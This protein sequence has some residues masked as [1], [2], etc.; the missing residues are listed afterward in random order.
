VKTLRWLG[1]GAL[2]CIW[3]LGRA[4]AGEATGQDRAEAAGKRLVG[5]PAPRMVMRT[6]DGDTIDL[7]A[8]Y[9][10]KSVYL[11][12]WATWCVPC[13]QQ[14]PHFEHTYETA[15]SD[16]AVIAVNAGFNDSLEEIRKYRRALGITMPIVLDDGRLGAAFNLRVTPQHIVIGRDGRIQYVG[17]LADARLDAAL[18]AARQTGFPEAPAS[19]PAMAERPAINLGDRLPAQSVTTL[20]GKPFAFRMPATPRPTV[21]VFISPWCESYLATTRPAISASCRRTRE[22][23]NQLAQDQRV[24]WIGIASGLWASEE[25]L[26]K[27][28]DDYKIGI[29][30]TLDESG[31]LFRAFRVADVP[32][33]LIA[34]AR[35]KLIR[36]MVPDDA[37]SLRKAIG[38]L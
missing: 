1:V 7:G 21:L 25:D 26:R 19:A 33:V 5:S 29:P 30:L 17:H 3:V 4:L 18:V 37:E 27:Y 38:T 14:M 28:R 11:K 36:R 16:L 34:D 15:G 6:I 20:D 2:V 31:A 35:G 23:F 9:G 22:Q 12:F 32:T 24:R 13:R 8:L 10:K